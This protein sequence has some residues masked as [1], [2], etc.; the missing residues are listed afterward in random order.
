MFDI[1]IVGCGPAGMTAAIYAL[2]DGK[3][4]LILEKETI[5]GKIA[6]SPRVDNYPG[7]KHI[8]GVHLAN[9]LYE[10]VIDLG[11]IVEIEE[12][13]KIIPGKIKTIITDSNKYEA[14]AIII[15]SG[16]NYRHLG[17]V[18]EENFIGNGISFCTVCDG[19]FYKGEDVAVVGGGNSAVINALSLAD[20]C[21]TV[22]LI[23]RKDFLRSAKEQTKELETKDN[24]KIMY[25]S[26]IVKIN[27]DENIES[28]T[29]KRKDEEKTLMVSG[30]FLAIG[31]DAETDY[32]E[33]QIKLNKDNYIEANEAMETNVDGIFVAGDVRE[34]S[35]RQLTT[36]VSDG[37]IAALSALEYLKKNS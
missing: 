22:Y 12:V 1:I 7:L 15:A 8:K 32:L 5:G 29:I 2:R 36:A 24:I 30:I 16:T 17:L 33:K 37:T 28:I 3:K 20:I 35:I 18:E 23:V 11:G 6:S 10:Q 14:K 34:K 27:G 19:A 21:K 4:V 31:Q 13:K 26:N 25:E 9:N